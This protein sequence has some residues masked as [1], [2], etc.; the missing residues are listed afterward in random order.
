MPVG[1]F[2]LKKKIVIV[3]QPLCPPDL[4]PADF[5]LCPKL[6]TPI[7]EKYF[8]MIKEKKEKSIQKLLAIPKNRV[9]KECRELEKT[10]ASVYYI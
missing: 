2:L 1:E 8:A 7:K 3:P 10:L 5:F 6:K 9:S 4:A